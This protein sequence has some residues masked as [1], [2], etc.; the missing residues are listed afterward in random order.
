MTSID[1]CGAVSIP[2]ILGAAI[3]L[4]ISGPVPVPGRIGIATVIALG[5][6]LRNVPSR[7]AST[8]VASG[9]GLGP[10]SVF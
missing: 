10:V 7:T 2:S 1:S 4:I 6:T 8:S 5:R 9:L 3:R